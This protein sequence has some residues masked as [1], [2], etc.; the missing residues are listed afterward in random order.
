MVI[1]RRKVLVGVGA[2]VTTSAA[3]RAEARLDGR[4]LIVGGVCR[5]ADG[6]FRAVLVDLSGRTV[7]AV[8]LPGRGHDLAVSPSGD[9]CV[10]FARRPGTFA[11]AFSPKMRGK[12]VHFTPPSGRHFYGHGIFSP[13]GRLLYTTEN[14]FEQGIGVIGVFDA[15]NGFARVGEF[16]SFGTGPH[17]L[18]LLGD[19][20]CLVVANGGYKEHPAVGAGRT[21]LNPDTYQ[22]DLCLIDRRHGALIERYEFPTAERV[23]FRHLAVAGGNRIVVGAQGSQTAHDKDLVFVVSRGE[24]PKPVNLPLGAMP[25]LGGYVSSVAVSA[26][27]STAAITSSRSN[28]VVLF[29]V[30]RGTH[31]KSWPARDVSGVTEIGRGDRFVVSTG[32]GEISEICRNAE[33]HTI[34]VDSATSWDNHLVAV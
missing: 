6:R 29:D 20:N 25:S 18:G 24:R 28:L 26:D 30:R 34:G 33:P 32:F 27:G 4:P 31:L 7:A 19:G 14:D 16:P 17:D 3:D 5:S 13:D 15:T 9:V 1:D 10:A 2:A 21:I 8:P 12:A 11:V 23:S 22:S